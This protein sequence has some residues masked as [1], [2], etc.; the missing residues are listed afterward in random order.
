MLISLTST[1]MDEMDL[2]RTE[3]LNKTTGSLSNYVLLPSFCNLVNRGR[4]TKRQA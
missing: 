2:Q 1:I 3:E 4:E